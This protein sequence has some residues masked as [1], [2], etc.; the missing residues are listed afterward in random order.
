M[1]LYKL[2]GGYVIITCDKDITRSGMR[3]KEPTEKQICIA[4][5]KQF[6]QL[7][8]LNYFKKL[9]VLFHI[10]NEQYTS[11]GY[12]M[13]LKAMGLLSGVADYC[14]LIDGGKVA[15]IEFKRNAKCKLSPNQ[16]WFKEQCEVM[17]IPYAVVHTIEAAMAF[18]QSL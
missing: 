2:K 1:K 9:I 15:F 4:F 14:V 13:S 10:A 8:G 11:K 6:S 16:L 7:Q 17:G 3:T 12:T 5:Y 18:L